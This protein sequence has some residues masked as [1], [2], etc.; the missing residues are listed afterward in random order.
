[1]TELPHLLMRRRLNELVSAPIW[2]DG[3]HLKAFTESHAAE[4]HALLELAYADG[5]GTVPPFA[6]WWPLL[7]QDSE[8]DPALCFLV[9]DGED[10][11]TSDSCPVPCGDLGF[12]RFTVLSRECPFAP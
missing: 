8:Y 3:V 7:S 10:R 9:C 6:E 2:P 4:V 1:M 12:H 5:G 11:P